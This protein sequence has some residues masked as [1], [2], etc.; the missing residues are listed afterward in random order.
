MK[1]NILC[2]FAAAFFLLVTGVT[3]AGAATDQ[4]D[5]SL[6]MSSFVNYTWADVDMYHCADSGCFPLTKL[7]A[8]QPLDDFCFVVGRH[9]GTSPYW[10]YVYDRRT[11]HYGY[12]PEYYLANQTQGVHC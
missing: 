3:T 6:T 7:Y 10:D 8:W 5:K 1:R 12:V 4:P 11:G 2:A 9:V